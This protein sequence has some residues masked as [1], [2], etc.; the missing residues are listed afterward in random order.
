MLGS[1]QETREIILFGYGKLGHRVYEMLSANFSNIIVADSREEA[2]ERAKEDGVVTSFHIDMTDDTALEELGLNGKILFCSMDDM[3]LN[4]FLVLSLKSIST[5]STIISVSTSAENTRKLKFIGADKVID[6][7]ESSANRIVDIITR[8]AVTRVLDEI[9]YVDNGISI[10][11]IEIPPNSFLES[12]YVYEIDFREYGLILIGITDK[13]L[14]EDFIF[15]SRGINHKFDAGD[16]LVLLGESTAL[17]K[18]YT[19]LTE[20]K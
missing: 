2:I 5:D 6:L 14:G 10:E 1:N 12:K 19:M 17:E 11:E 15:V 7:Y 3:S 9:I 4:I 13:E 20:R 16:I 18:F 8:P